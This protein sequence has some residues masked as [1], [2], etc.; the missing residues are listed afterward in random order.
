MCAPAPAPAPASTPAPAPAPLP[1][2]LTTT[3]PNDG[4]DQL[5][6]IVGQAQAQR[7]GLR[8]GVEGAFVQG[9][10]QDGAARALRRR[11]AAAAAAR[12]RCRQKEVSLLLCSRCLGAL[13]ACSAMANKHQSEFPQPRGMGPRPLPRPAKDLARPRRTCG[14][15]HVPCTRPVGCH[16]HRRAL[17]EMGHEASLE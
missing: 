15:I 16:H 2:R 6:P 1:Y 9:D 8:H 17:P 10:H 5:A 3:T 7:N 12:S 14:A 11:A 4:R 13:A